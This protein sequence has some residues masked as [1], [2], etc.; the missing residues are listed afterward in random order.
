MNAL[1]QAADIPVRNRH[2]ASDLNII[3]TVNLLGF[4]ML[5][6]FPNET[7]RLLVDRLQ[8]MQKVPMNDIVKRLLGWIDYYG[9]M[10]SMQVRLVQFITSEIPGSEIKKS[11]LF[12]LRIACVLRDSSFFSWVLD[13][14]PLFSDN[15]CLEMSSLDTRLGLGLWIPTFERRLNLFGSVFRGLRNLPARVPPR[16]QGTSAGDEWRLVMF[17]W[18]SWLLDRAA[19]SQAEYE[20]INP[21]ILALH[22]IAISKDVPRYYSHNSSTSTAE[23]ASQCLQ[24]ALIMAKEEIAR[25]ITVDEHEPFGFQINDYDYFPWDDRSDED[26]DEMLFNLIATS[27]LLAVDEDWN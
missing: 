1:D 2:E 4:S 15:V 17:A 6:Y 11:I 26:T 12:Y 18:N 19:D 23:N 24:H 8:R 10:T 5:C 3:S 25:H 9:T 20:H 16:I 7:D 13:K 22:S 27:D 21:S 14:N